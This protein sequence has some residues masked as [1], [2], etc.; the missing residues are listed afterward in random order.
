MLNEQERCS[1]F[2]EYFKDVMPNATTELR[3]T[4]GFELL[5]AVVLSAQCTDK[6]INQVV[7]ALFRAY[8]SAKSLSMA[9][10]DDIFPYIRSVSYPHNKTKHIR[11]LSKI[12]VE[13]F[14][15]EIP[16]T[17]ELL[18][19]LPGV[20][21]K[22]ANVILSVLFDEPTMAVDTHILR[23]SHRIGLVSSNARNP[24]QI[25]KELVNNIPV[26]HLAQAHHW[27]ILHGRYTCIARKPKCN[28]CG[29]KDICLYYSQLQN[30][31]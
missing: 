30:G 18:E 1:L 3:Y 16:R 22:T 7:P 13:K 31:K 5:I 25:E 28:E 2:C 29:I 14:Q 21:R 17:R 10:Y 15:G 23:L 27:L 8:P 9:S 11:D 6:R 4:N 20:G 19:M 24:L 26:E 12:L